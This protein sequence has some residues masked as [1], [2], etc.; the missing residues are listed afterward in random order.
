MTEINSFQ[1]EYK[2]LSNFFLCDINY[3]GR[4]YP[5]AE[6]A[7]QA[8]KSLKQMDQRK[9][10]RLDNPGH[11]KRAGRKLKIRPDWDKIKLDIMKAILEV[12]F[13][14]P[15]LG[16]KLMNTSPAKLIEGNNWNDTYW[17]ICKGQGLNNLGIILMSIRDSLEYNQMSTTE[18]LVQLALGTFDPY[19]LAALV[20]AS[21][22]PSVLTA[23]AKYFVGIKVG[24][25]GA[26]AD[27][28]YADT[29]LNAFIANENT[30][31]LVKEYVMLAR[32]IKNLEN[33]KRDKLT[34][35]A[36]H[37][38]NVAKEPLQRN[39]DRIHSLLFED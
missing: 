29:I 35:K 31:P 27:G 18:L 32:Q 10:A 24:S 7:F 12:K 34:K 30:P 22:D 2:F 8:Q 14:G 4:T 13:K 26:I 33:C 1:G 25:D 21:K 39:L 19:D 28:A 11:A 15:E 20:H 16:Q 37:Y 17:G 9:I 36:S 38:Y 23:T 3:N 6:H 5:S